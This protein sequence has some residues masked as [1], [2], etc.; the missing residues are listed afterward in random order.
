[1]LGDWNLAP[2]ARLCPS[3]YLP[4]FVRKYRQMY[5]RSRTHLRR[6]VYPDAY[7]H[8]Y[9]YLYLDLCPSLFLALF[10][11]FFQKAFQKPFATLYAAI[12]ANKYRRLNDLKYR[13]LYRPMPPPRQSLGRP[14]HGK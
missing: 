1:V 13:D 9:L 6:H 2:K 14:L 4:L 11:W 3:K 12:I 8:L 7:L 5:L 10:E